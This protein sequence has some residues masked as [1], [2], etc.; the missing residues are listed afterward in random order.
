LKRNNDIFELVTSRIALVLYL[1]IWESI[2]HAKLALNSGN[3][4]FRFKLTR[5]KS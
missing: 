5:I 4:I 2:R 3:F 1:F